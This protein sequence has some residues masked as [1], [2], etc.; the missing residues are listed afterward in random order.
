MECTTGPLGTGIATSVGMAIAGLWQAATFNR[1]GYDLFDYDVY[2][3]VRRR[4]PDGRHRRRSRIAGRAPA[5]VEPVLDLRQQQDHH[6]GRHRTGLHRGRRRPVHRLRLG[7]APRHRRQRPRRAHRRAARVQGRA[8]PPDADHRRQ[9]HRLRRPHQGRHPLRARRTARRRGDPRRE[10]GLRLAARREFLV[11][12]G[13]REHLADGRVNAAPQLREQWDEAVRPVQ[14][15]VPRTRR[16][17]GPDAAPAAAR[18]LGRR[19]A[20]VPRRPEGCCR[21]RRQRQGA[22]RGRRRRCRG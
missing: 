2:A 7:R 6:R 20:R 22:E 13:V 15:R 1:P 10:T 19:H 12:D 3:I 8:D 18:R 21:P 17:A 9:R 14:R 16:P 4:L 11:P 5:A